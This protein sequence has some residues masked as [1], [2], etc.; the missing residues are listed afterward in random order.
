M[1]DFILEIPKWEGE[2]VFSQELITLILVIIALITGVLLCFWGYRYFKTIALILVGCICGF[3]GYRIGEGMTSNLVL[4]MCIFV[5][6]TFVGVCMLF[7]LSILW[8]WLLDKLK[9][10]SFIQRTLHIIASLSGALMV[11]GI[12]YFRV[13]QNLLVVVIIAGVLAIAGI[14]YGMRNVKARR[15][16][17][18]YEDLRKLKPLTEDEL[19]A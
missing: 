17:R 12:T 9:I 13:Y 3:I 6:F 10:R 7:F 16:F 18:T 4:Q 2:I 5:M 1:E 15:V 14:W 11:G 19:N 8:V